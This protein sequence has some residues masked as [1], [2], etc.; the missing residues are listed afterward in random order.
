MRRLLVRYERRDDLYEGL[1]RL[2][3]ALICFNFLLPTFC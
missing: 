2:G 1:H 3:C